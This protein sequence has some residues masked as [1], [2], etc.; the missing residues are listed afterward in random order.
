MT[1]RDAAYSVSTTPPRNRLPGIG[2]KGVDR[3]TIQRSSFS[4]R[5]QGEIVSRGPETAIGHNSHLVFVGVCVKHHHTGG[6]KAKKLEGRNAGSA[7]PGNH[8][9]WGAAQKA[10]GKK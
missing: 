7:L 3:K 4:S 10:N 6:Y 9:Q 5:A 8:S 1:F 2:V